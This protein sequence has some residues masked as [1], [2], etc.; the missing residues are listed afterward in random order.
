MWRQASAGSFFLI[1]AGLVAIGLLS[2]FRTGAIRH[3]TLPS[4]RDL[5]TEVRCSSSGATFMAALAG[6]AAMAWGVAL[7]EGNR[8]EAAALIAAGLFIA[9]AGTAARVSAFRADGDGLVILF[10]RRQGFRAPWPELHALK[11]PATPLG[12]WT[13]IDVRGQRRTLMPSD[14]LG[15]EELLRLIVIRSG[16]RFDGRLWRQAPG[17]GRRRGPMRIGSRSILKG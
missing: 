16:M 1:A 12:G 15:H 8:I 2:W 6:M 4:V 10:A 11:P 5:P 7:A 3:G 13:L 14:L 9:V 17:D